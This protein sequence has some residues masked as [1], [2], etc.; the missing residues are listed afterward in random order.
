MTE[1]EILEID[2][3]DLVG[4]AVVFMTD[5]DKIDYWNGLWWLSDS[6]KLKPKEG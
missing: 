2:F 4:S 6:L 5:K 3:Y 1:S